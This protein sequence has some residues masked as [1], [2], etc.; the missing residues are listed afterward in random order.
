MVG[1]FGFKP[2]PINDYL[3][4]TIIGTAIFIVLIG[5]LQLRQDDRLSEK[6]FVDLTKMVLEQ[7][8]LISNI[9]KQFQGNK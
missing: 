8:P 1:G 6:F 2:Q 9:I 4:L 5:V 7:L 3:A